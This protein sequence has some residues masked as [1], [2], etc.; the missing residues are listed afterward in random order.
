M[1]KADA[2]EVARRATNAQVLEDVERLVGVRNEHQARRM[3]LL[4]SPTIGAAIYAAAI[5][6]AGHK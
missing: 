6:H 3:L 5:Q 4:F 1:A 2:E